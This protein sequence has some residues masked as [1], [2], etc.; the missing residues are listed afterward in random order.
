MKLFAAL[1]L[2]GGALQGAFATDQK[3][4]M[5]GN[6][7]TVRNNLS[8]MLQQMLAETESSGALVTRSASG[9]YRLFQHLQLALGYYGIQPLREYLVTDPPDW[10]HVVLQEQSQISG[11]YEYQSFFVPTTDAV[12]SLVNMAT[13]AGARP[14]FFVTWGRRDGDYRNPWLY[15]DFKT[16]QS[17]LNE[18]YRRFADACPA[19]P[20]LAPVGT[21][22]EVI[23]D[24]YVEMGLNPLDPQSNFYRLYDRDGSHPS[25][26]GSYLSALVIYA[27]I[28]GNDPRD[29]KYVP[30]GISSD[31]KDM[32][33]AVAALVTHGSDINNPDMMIAVME[34]VPVDSPYPTV[35]PSEAPSE[36]PELELMDMEMCQSLVENADME[37]GSEGYWYGRGVGTIQDV[38]PGY[39]SDTAIRSMERH[40]YW[41]GPGY[42][43]NMS[44]ERGCLI[45]GT[46]W[47]VT[48]QVK[49]VNP[50]NND[51]GAA[52]ELAPDAGPN[53][54]C[55]QVRVSLRDAHWRLSNRN[56]KGYTKATWDPNDF[57]KFR[58]T[59]TVPENSDKWQGPI[60]NV[61][62][63]FQMYDPELD[64][65]LDDFNMVLVS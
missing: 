25:R 4:L 54:S 18:G 8:L 39:N 60:A 10:N 43:I 41:D 57:N 33:Q 17:K 29:L 3:V 58:A 12:V 28:T 24:R 59:F 38:S 30:T 35:P 42:M 5:V 65:I 22:F 56:I 44:R 49:L 48:A 36:A 51:E 21:A 1:T 34:E 50:T 15:P 52:C 31:Q 37:L 61:V 2:L 23:H 47:L 11:F 55:P 46:K 63:Y 45:P 20:L 27:T 40:R 13:K 32:L 9:G 53:V 62:V 6:S 26:L 7:Y 14:V 16:M 64:L 19:P